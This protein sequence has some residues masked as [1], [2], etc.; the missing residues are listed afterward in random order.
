[1]NPNS[2]NPPTTTTRGNACW[3]PY[4]LPKE[5]LLADSTKLLHLCNN[6]RI[7]ILD[8]TPMERFLNNHSPGMFFF[9]L[10]THS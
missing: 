6:M 8:E 10:F 5:T 7:F 3:N 2:N 4:F 1:M 9:I